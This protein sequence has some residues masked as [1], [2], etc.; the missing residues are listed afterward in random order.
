MNK[1]TNFFREIKARLTGD[2][3]ELTA[4]KNERKANAAFKSQLAALEAKLV[5]D[6]ANA[7]EAKELYDKTLYPTE[8]ITNNASYISSVIRAKEAMEKANAEVEDTKASIAF[9]KELSEKE[10]TPVEA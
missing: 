3:A 9:F 1:T 5:D 2:S 4:A 10:F 7:S 8:L 6:E